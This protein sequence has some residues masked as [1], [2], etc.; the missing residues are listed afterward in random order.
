MRRGRSQLGAAVSGRW[1]GGA[2]GDLVAGAG[3]AGNGDGGAA[4]SHDADEVYDLTD[5]GAFAHEEALPGG[6]GGGWTGWHVVQGEDRGGGGKTLWE[7]GAKG[8]EG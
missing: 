2:G 4:G 5:G 8:R 1:T 7:E 3:L 6:V